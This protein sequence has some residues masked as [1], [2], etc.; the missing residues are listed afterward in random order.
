SVLFVGGRGGLGLG[1]RAAARGDLDL[2]AVAAG[3][4]ADG[5][6]RLLLVAAAIAARDRAVAAETRALDAGIGDLGGE[7][8]DGADRGVVARDDVVDE[9]RIAVGVGDADD[10]DLE[11]ARLL[12][13]DVLL[14][15]IDHEDRAGEA[16]H[17]LD[18][19]E[20]L[21]ELDALALER[22]HFLLAQAIEG[23]VL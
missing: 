18:A 10:R 13:G 4:D 15:R 22:E 2:G 1:A 16:A 21:L 6:L 17:G 3:R 23:A 11:A 9:V 12:D 7:Q 5:L 19:A 8:L 14:L 20:R